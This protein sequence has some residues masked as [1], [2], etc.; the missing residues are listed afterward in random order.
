[1]DFFAV[2]LKLLPNS[3]FFEYAGIVLNAPCWNFSTDFGVLG[4]LGKLL[5]LVAPTNDFEDLL[6]GDV[7]L[8]G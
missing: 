1:M 4:K 2:S 5:G 8:G 7:G 6:P 3:Y